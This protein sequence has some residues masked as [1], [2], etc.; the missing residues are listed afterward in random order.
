M[1]RFSIDTTE[2]RVE[3]TATIG[4]GSTS[5][6]VTTAIVGTDPELFSLFTGPESGVRQATGSA[7]IRSTGT[8]WLSR[9]ELD[10]DPTIVAL[11]R[12]FTWEFSFSSE[13]YYF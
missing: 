6:A 1:A 3:G 10:E 8:N 7:E 11:D 12:E 9:L 13:P 4:T 2:G 5:F